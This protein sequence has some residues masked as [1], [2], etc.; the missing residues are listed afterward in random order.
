MTM[1]DPDHLELLALQLTDRQPLLA[2]SLAA[3]VAPVL[4]LLLVAA[5]TLFP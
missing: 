2:L 3:V 4:F 5:L 1:T